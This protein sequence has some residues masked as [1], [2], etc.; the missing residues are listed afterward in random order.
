MI[1]DA[2]NN[3]KEDKEKAVGEGLRDMKD[4]SPGDVFSK[5]D[6]DA[7]KY[8]KKDEGMENSEDSDRNTSVGS[9]LLN[10]DYKRFEEDI[11]KKKEEIDALKDILKRRQADFENYKKRVLKSQEEYRKVAIKDMALDII[12]INDDLLRAIEAAS[13]VREG[14]KPVGAHNS[15]VEGVSMISKRIEEMLLKYGVAEIK[16]LGKGFD[17]NSSEAMEIDESA[18]VG[19]DTV[20]KVYR[21]GFSFDNYVLRAAKVRVTRPAKKDVVNGELSEDRVEANSD[22]LERND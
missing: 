9:N 3:G 19:Q 8:V 22:T 16:P 18:E 10:E 1:K 11:A 7:G 14:E 20:T 12:D 4:S 21:K 2:R 13:E 6:E 5:D 15:F 17:P